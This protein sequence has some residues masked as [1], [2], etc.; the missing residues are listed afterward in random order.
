MHYAQLEKKKIASVSAVDQRAKVKRAG[1]PRAM[2]FHFC[3]VFFR[4]A[5]QRKD[6]RPSV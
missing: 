1:L 2:L 4:H 5:Q 3:D 6:T